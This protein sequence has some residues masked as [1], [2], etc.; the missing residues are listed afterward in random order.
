MKNTERRTSSLGTKVA[1]LIC[2][3]CCHV[4]MSGSEVVLFVEVPAQV[5]A[6]AGQI[7]DRGWNAEEKTYVRLGMVVI[8]RSTLDIYVQRKQAQI[9]IQ[10]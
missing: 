9:R 7:G 3:P 10:Y 1:A 6:A 8:S 2:V 4:V 5:E